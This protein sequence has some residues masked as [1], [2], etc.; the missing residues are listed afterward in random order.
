MK[1]LL[2]ADIGFQLSV[3]AAG[4]GRDVVITSGRGLHDRPVAEHTLALVLA[5]ARRLNLLVPAQVEHRWAAELGGVQPIEDH[6]SFRTLRG[7]R[8]TI[9]GFGSIATTLAPLLQALGAT[10]TGLARSAGT[11]SGFT[12]V[13]DTDIGTVLPGTDVLI[14]ILPGIVGNHGIQ[15]QPTR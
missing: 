4:F 10:V 15:R 1:V 11:R 9:W 2:P 13:A 12:V 6:G 14:A 5:A 3:F 8:V 7:A